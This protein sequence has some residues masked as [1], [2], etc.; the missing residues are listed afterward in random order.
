MA[1][2]FQRL[3]KDVTNSTNEAMAVRALADILADRE[4]RAFISSLDRKDAEYCID[5]LDRVSH[6]LHIQPSPEVSYG[7]VR[8]S[9]EI[10]S[11]PSR[12]NRLS[13]SH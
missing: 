8:A 2:N 1:K 9:Q 3:W 13:S 7:L 4:G 5:I 11:K 12:R 10:I 6:N